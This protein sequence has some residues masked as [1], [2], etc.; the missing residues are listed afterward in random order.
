MPQYIIKLINH[1]IDRH[2]IDKR[3][4]ILL[5]CQMGVLGFGNLYMNP[6][7]LRAYCHVWCIVDTNSLDFKL[8][9]S[10]LGHLKNVDINRLRSTPI[11][12]CHDKI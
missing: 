5:G 9:Q 7:F 2:H 12:I 10:N 3:E 8:G 1:L 4:Y 11:Y 6:L